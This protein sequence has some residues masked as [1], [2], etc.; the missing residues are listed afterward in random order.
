[1][2][3]RT[4]RWFR[5]TAGYVGLLSPFFSHYLWAWGWGVPYRNFNEEIYAGIWYGALILAGMMVIPVRLRRITARVV[6]ALFAAVHTAELAYLL[7]VGAVP[8][9]ATFHLIFDTNSQEISEFLRQFGPQILKAL[10]WFFLQLGIVYV[11][12]LGDIPRLRGALAAGT[13]FILA[14]LPLGSSRIKE[15]ALRRWLPIRLFDSYRSY[16]IA[17][18]E[19]RR[20]T[21]HPRLLACQRL[22]ASDSE[23]YV[24]IIGESLSRYHMGLYGYERPTTPRLS[25]RSDLIVFDSAQAAHMHTTMAL[26]CMLLFHHDERIPPPYRAASVADYAKQAG[27]TTYW[28]SNQPPL[29]AWENMTTLIAERTDIQHFVNRLDDPAYASVSYDEKIFPVL[30]RVLTDTPRRKLVFIHLLGSHIL[31]KSRYPAPFERFTDTPRPNL[32]APQIEI[33]NAYDNSILYNDFVVDSILRMVAQFS[34]FSAAIY[35]ADHGD[36]VFTTK[37]IPYHSEDHPTPPMAAVPLIVWV[38]KRFHREQACRVRYLRRIR[39]RPFDLHGFQ[40]LVLQLMGFEG[41]WLAP[42]PM[43]RPMADSASASDGTT[44]RVRS[45]SK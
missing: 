8:S 9:A 16:R 43:C 11:L 34:P 38:S 18:E 15:G 29:G 41:E 27:F 7:A 5:W 32:S 25:A 35:V 2:K 17:K 19:I 39:S 44:G 4:P 40:R 26:R 37:D 21:Q 6:L 36:D 12:P 30:Q 24:I 13:A 42:I 1:M 33:F 10:P 22:P 45:P 20:Y 28:I 23:T 14:T 31:Y 3:I